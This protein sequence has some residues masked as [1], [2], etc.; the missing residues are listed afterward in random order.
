MFRRVFFSVAVA[1]LAI[2]TLTAC[3]P[4]LPPEVLAALAEQTFICEPGEVAVSYPNSM[5]DEASMNGDAILGNCADMFAT[6]A[7]SPSAADLQISQSSEPTAECKAFASVPYAIDAAVVITNMPNF[8]ALNLTPNLASDIFS[9]KITS[10][11]DPAFEVSNPGYIPEDTAITVI[12]QTQQNALDS[13]GAWMKTI[14][15]KSFSATLLKPEAELDPLAFTE[16]PYGAIAL[17]PNSLNL[18]YALN[19]M[20]TP[21]VASIMVDK[22]P[23]NAVFSDTTT[24]IPSAATQFKVT[25]TETKVVLKHDSSITPLPPIGSDVAPAPYE[26]IYP[27]SLSLCGADTK[28]KRAV[29]RYLL[30]QDSQGMFVNVVALP[31]NVRGESLALVSKG[32]PQPTAAPEN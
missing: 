17:V 30:R 25:K 10:W 12:P 13:F 11:N 31:E 16:L 18:V 3:D 5:A 24:S 6:I 27:V 29:A 14:S 9:G 4:P 7:D 20:D 26:A 21:I 22:N 28:V 2:G 15:G 1:T 19:A 8:G 23:D 32:L